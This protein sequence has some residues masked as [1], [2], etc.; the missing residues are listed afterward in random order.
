MAHSVVHEWLLRRK[1]LGLT[2]G[3]LAAL[4]AAVLVSGFVQVRSPRRPNQASASIPAP[5]T[6]TTN[7]LPMPKTAPQVAAGAVPAGVTVTAA[8]AEVA[9]DQWLETPGNY[10]PGTTGTP[11]LLGRPRVVSRAAAELATDGT[12]AGLPAYLWQLDYRWPV[13]ILGVPRSYVVLYVNSQTGQVTMGMGT[14][15]APTS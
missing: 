15:T 1:G 3:A 7:Q 2:V 6:F 14:N 11:A 9:A 10:V 8:Q 13:S 5:R 4:G 12:Q